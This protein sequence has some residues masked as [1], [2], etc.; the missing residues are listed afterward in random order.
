MAKREQNS[1]T[2]NM[3]VV[4]ITVGALGILGTKMILPHRTQQATVAPV[5]EKHDFDPIVLSGQLST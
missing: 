3:F 1:F 5:Q 4:A 2:L